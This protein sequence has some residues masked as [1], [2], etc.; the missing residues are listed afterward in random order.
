MF[1]W[2][3]SWKVFDF[4]LYYV[5]YP[6]TGFVRRMFR[7][8]LFLTIFHTLL[9]LSP[10]IDDLTEFHTIFEK[11]YQRMFHTST[12]FTKNFHK[13][14]TSD[15][16]WRRNLRKSPILSLKWCQKTERKKVIT[17]LDDCFASCTTEMEKL[18]EGEDFHKLIQINI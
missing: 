6:V 5:V 3:D 1:F 7:V 15:R 14:S 8:K 10:F 4:F 9:F 17:N 11:L 2:R 12:F 16:L 13:S 18:G